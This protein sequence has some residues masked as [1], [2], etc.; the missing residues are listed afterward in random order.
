MLFGMLGCKSIQPSELAG[1]WAMTEHS[2]Q[3]LP[4]GLQKASGKI[5]LN[6]DGT[7]N[8]SELPGLLY[9]PP[10]QPLLDSGSS[11][12]KLVSHD[13]RQQIQIVFEATTSGSPI[14]VPF[15]TYIGV[16]RGWSSVSLFYFLG[17]ADEGRRIEFVQ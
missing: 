10:D 7:F 17:D 9:F 16:S 6:A 15:G 4:A 5:I 1:T 2:R 14:K 13:D 12:W 3:V 8:A 11:I